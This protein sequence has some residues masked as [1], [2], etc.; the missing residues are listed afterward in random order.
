MIAFRKLLLSASTLTL[1]VAAGCSTSDG[2]SDRSPGTSA[3][4]SDASN[5]SPIK[6]GIICSCSGGGGFSAFNVPTQ[7]AVEA[8]AKGVNESGGINGHSIDIVAKDDGGVP[9]Q[10]LS[11]ATDL[12]NENVSAII[13][14]SIIDQPWAAMV[15]KAKIPVVGAYSDSEPFTTMPYFFPEGQSGKSIN[16]AVV[17]IGQQAG[18]S[19]IGYLYCVETPRCSE[20]IPRVKTAAKQEGVPFVF[21]T[22]ISAT[23]PDYTAQ[24]VAAKQKGV[25]ALYIS[26]ASVVAARIG[27]D[28]K[29]QGF[30][31]IY[32]MQGAAFGM[33]TATAPGLKDHLSLQFATLPFFAK[34]PAVQKFNAAMDKYFPGVREDASVFI[35]DAFQ[36]WVS[37]K[38]LEHAIKVSGATSGH[39]VTAKGVVS[40]LESLRNYTVDGLAPPLTFQPGVPHNVDCWFAGRIKNGVPEVVNDGKPTCAE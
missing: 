12:V 30:N 19:N 31:P 32:L 40:G 26:S 8:W 1:V 4:S 39:E 10:G 37:A 11:A 21:N 18:A 17:K 7:D 13:D 28:C 16:E 2:P 36:G 6:V 23:A 22:G 25:S 35:Q 27:S 14:I 15:N 24:C 33:K 3:S 20:N 38:L 5:G 9:G 29:R 34:T